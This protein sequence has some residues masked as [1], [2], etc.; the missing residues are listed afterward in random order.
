LFLAA[1]NFTA[2]A[3][4]YR[5]GIGSGFLGLLSLVGRAGLNLGNL[6]K[7]TRVTL[8]FLFDCFS[9]T[10]NPLGM[11]FQKKSRAFELFNL[12]ISIPGEFQVEIARGLNH[13]KKK[14]YC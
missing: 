6:E 2:S 5:L 11:K 7:E 4:C 1:A 9:G 3:V 14:E 8:F 12:P 13:N 10:L